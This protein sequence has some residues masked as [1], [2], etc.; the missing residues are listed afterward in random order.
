MDRTQSLPAVNGLGRMDIPGKLPAN[1]VP[2][3]R[4]GKFYVA[5]DGREFD[6]PPTVNDYPEFARGSQSSL[7]SLVLPSASQIKSPSNESLPVPKAVPNNGSSPHLPRSRTDVLPFLQVNTNGPFLGPP[8]SSSANQLNPGSPNFMQKTTKFNS[9]SPSSSVSSLSSIAST[10]VDL[11]KTDK[12]RSPTDVFDEG[13]LGS[14]AEIWMKTAEFRTSS[15]ILSDR[16]TSAVFVDCEL[17]VCKD[18]MNGIATR[19]Q[20]SCKSDATEIMKFQTG[21]PSQD[22]MP[23]NEYNTHITTETEEIPEPDLPPPLPEKRKP[24]LPPKPPVAPK[25]KVKPVPEPQPEQSPL[26]KEEVDFVQTFSHSRQPNFTE[27][28]DDLNKL[29]V[30]DLVEQFKDAMPAV[31]QPVMKQIG[32]DHYPPPEEAD[33]ARSPE[34]TS[35]MNGGDNIEAS[36]NL[37]EAYEMTF[38]DIDM[39]SATQNDLLPYLNNIVN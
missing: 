31:K 3:F 32:K 11:T 6:R 12:E 2:Y 25:P 29:S 26:E 23:V 13:R 18:A 19:Y 27:L 35:L 33:V 20:D 16:M 22:L 8:R 17:T 24:Q 28:N 39:I 4:R 34:D 36:G 30:H 14:D 7:N 9:Q 15:P 5:P 37:G 1:Q 38:A 10:D 21:V